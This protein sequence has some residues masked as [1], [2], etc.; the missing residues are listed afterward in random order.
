M[1]KKIYRLLLLPILPAIAI[2]LAL[3]WILGVGETDAGEPTK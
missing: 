2:L 1:S 3:A